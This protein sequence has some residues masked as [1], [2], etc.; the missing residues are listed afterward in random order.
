MTSD[1]NGTAALAALVAARGLRRVLITNSAMSNIGGSQIVCRDLA[2]VLKAAGAEVSIATLA[3]AEPMR[4]LCETYR[5]GA[6]APM[7]PR[8]VSG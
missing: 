8:A 3:I 1:S 7:R 5:A 2:M 4:A 6:T